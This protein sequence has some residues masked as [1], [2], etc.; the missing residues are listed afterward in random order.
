M[1]HSLV[2][3]AVL[4]ALLA[5]GAAGIVLAPSTIPGSLVTPPRLE[6]VDVVPQSF[7]DPR[8]ATFA[9]TTA[10]AQSVRSGAGGTLTSFPC[11]DGGTLASGSAL[12]AVDGR[13]VI[14]LATSTPLWRDLGLG[15]EGADVAALQTEL[16]RL[17]SSLVIDGVFGRVDAEALD[18]VIVAA[19]GVAP[20]SPGAHLDTI[21]WMPAPV[22]TVSSCRAAAGERVAPGQQ[23]ADLPVALTSAR[24]APLPDAVAGDR[25]IVADGVE[26]PV[27]ADGIITDAATL[28]AVLASTEY[29]QARSESTTA[30]VDFDYLLAS[31]IDAVAIPPSALYDL[32][33][34]RGCVQ[35]DGVAVRVELLASQLGQALVVPARS[36]DSV[37]LHPDP[38]VPC[39]P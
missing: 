26:H 22:V 36:L 13:P 31:P 10:P 39:A 33:A 21:A 14:G 32:E 37:D 30:E 11:H 17:G 34:A 28:A 9:V 1:K 25:V 12:F 27:P 24:L 6:S 20:D 29:R 5:G 15:D 3:I 8:G 23:L 16:V 2:G 4:G 7:R 18:G 35:N 19:G 38:A